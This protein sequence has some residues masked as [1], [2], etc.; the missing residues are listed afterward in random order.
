[1]SKR[2]TITRAMMMALAVMRVRASNFIA[3]PPSVSG[4]QARALCKLGWLR[5]HEAKVYQHSSGESLSLSKR[6]VR[7]FRIT[8]AGVVASEADESREVKRAEFAADEGI[9]E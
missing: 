2:P 3:L 5:C 6:T 8:K 9:V 1:M 7:T 4:V